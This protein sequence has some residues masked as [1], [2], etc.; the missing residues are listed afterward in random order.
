MS[1][2]TGA[3]FTFAWRHAHRVPG[4]LLRAGFALAADV[5]WLRHGGGVRRLEANLARVRPELSAREV[6]RLS[7][8]SMRSYM[9]YYQEAFTLHAAT[10]EQITARVREEG[11]APVRAHLEAGR[12]PVLA[13]GHLGNWDL[14]GAWASTHLA[15][16]LTVAERLRPE[17]L[18]QEFLRFR[19]ALGIDIL[20]LGDTDVFRSL[21]RAARGPDR[22][23]PLLADRDLTA[24]GVEVD[25]LGHHARV[26]AGPA[27]LAVATGAPLFAVAITYERLRGS[28]RRAA[29]TPWGIV[30][31][32]GDEIVAEAL[33]LP[34][35][36]TK[37]Q[38]VTA[39][40]QAWVTDLA[41][42]IHEVPEDWHMLQRVFVADLDP[43]RD[44]AVRG[45][46]AA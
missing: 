46:G 23:L 38:R 25:L 33:D 37:E 8:R 3:L 5:A 12:S 39:T 26:A 34:P 31:R 36:A 32:F 44:A 43:A 30:L 18:F 13:L 11:S 24:S 4:P 17:E 21:V 42:T 22:I 15:R 45:A 9:R 14:A 10:P 41:R 35:D 7:R 40:T 19:T 6:R 2:D 27:S 16:V 29:G 28:R 1:L 20:A